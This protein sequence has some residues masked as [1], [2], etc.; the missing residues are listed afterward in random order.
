MERA[1][2]VEWQDPAPA[3]E[4]APSLSG[5]VYLQ[6][7]LDG[8]LPQPP[9]SSLVGM[10]FTLVEPGRVHLE[11]DPGEQHTNPLGTVHGGVISTM[12][13]SAMSCAVHTT[14]PAG[15]G[16][17]T[18][19]LSINLVRGITPAS[20]TVRAEGEVVHGGRRAATASGRLVDAS[21]KLCAHGTA[22]CLV[23]AP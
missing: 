6:A 19:E 3:L 13:D 5:L 18:L 11:L 12:L 1:L 4:R 2:T 21:G 9:I 14:L 15:T 23:L 17:T 20:G 22:T 8:E 10:R 16:Y 7:M